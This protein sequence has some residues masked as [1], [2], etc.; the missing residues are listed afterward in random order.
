ALQR[1]H[2]QEIDGKPHRAAPVAVAAKHP[3]VGLTRQVLHH[4]VGFAGA[5]HVRMFIVVARQRPN[6]ILRQK[7]AFVEHAAQ[8][9]LEAAAPHETQQVAGALTRLL[10]AR[11]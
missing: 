11:H 5:V 8:Q 4:K 10:P 1:L 9:R 3:R 7:L 6:T 2:N